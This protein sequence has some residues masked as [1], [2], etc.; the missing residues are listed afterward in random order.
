MSAPASQEA[1]TLSARVYLRWRAAW[2]F[3]LV[4]VVMVLSAAA[5]VVVRVVALG[6]GRR[7]GMNVVATG[8]ARALMWM[9]GVK[10]E[11]VG[12]GSWPSS[13][14]IYISNHTSTLDFFVVTGLGIPNLRAFMTRRLKVFIPVWILG[15]LLG[16]F[17]LPTQD[18][19]QGRARCF[20]AAARE[21]EASGDHVFLTPEG[22]R[23]VDGL[24][25]FNR[26]AFHLAAVLKWPI[27]PLFIEIPRRMN[28]G[29]GLQNRP[30]TLKVYCG[31]PIETV[32][33]TVERVDEQRDE[34]HALYVSRWWERVG[35]LS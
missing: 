15:E 26:G 14:C 24:G 31:A 27:V 23:N 13:P 10:V 35:G 5:L 22:T 12:F 4:M 25:R 3:V 20:E 2:V 19:P 33:W 6:G 32:D 30:G 28:P 1:K 21:L 7:F 17:F 8:G 16:H 9:A 11:R 29:K 34:V 18:D